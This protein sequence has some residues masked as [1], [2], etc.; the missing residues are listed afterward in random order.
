MA[1]NEDTGRAIATPRNRTADYLRTFFA[2]KA[3]GFKIY[4]VTDAQG[5]LHLIDSDNVIAHIHAAPLTEKMKIAE[6]IFRLDFANA[7][8]HHFLAHLAGALAAAAAPAW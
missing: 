3:L 6:M 2:E 7:D 5:N 8:I 4:E 1:N